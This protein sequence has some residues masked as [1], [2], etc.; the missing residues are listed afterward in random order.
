M[1]GQFLERPTLIPVGDEV[2]EG[3]SHR[4]TRRPPLLIVPPRPEEGSGMDHVVCAEVAWA[5]SQ[6]GFPTLRFNFRGVGAS[7]GKWGGT[8]AQLDEVL[9]ALRLAQENA[10]CARVAVLTL[11]GSAW[12]ALELSR[13][14]PAIAALCLVSP[15]GV[16]L[17]EL[18]RLSLPLSVVVAQ[19]DQ[20]LPRAGLS[21]AV[22][23]AGGALDIIPGTDASFLRNLTEV[24]KAVVSWLQRLDPPVE[25]G[26]V[27]M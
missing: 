1:K 19:D 18:A 22:G 4:G 7:Q 10:D 24:G 6:A 17:P 20:R 26:E 15:V 3:L 23:E 9:A 14:E 8:Q 13:T 21:A 11:G 5:A 27:E 16:D 12:S 25:H 2:M